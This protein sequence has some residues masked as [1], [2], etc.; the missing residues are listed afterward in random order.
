MLQ[1]KATQLPEKMQ[2][3]IMP[4]EDGCWLWT[5]SRQSDGYG[6]YYDR[7]TYTLAHRAVWLAAGRF[8]LEGLVSDHLCRQRL[9]VNP[10]HLEF[11]T[12]RENTLRGNTLAARFARRTHCNKGHE[13]T[14]ENTYWR[15]DKKR[16][17]RRCLACEKQRT[18]R[19]A[20][21]RAGA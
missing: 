19:R 1:M 21:M 8:I 12:S 11:V 18:V 4:V 2:D 15:S 20:A 13:Y 14:E 3:R 10:D 6:Y 17:A 5:G 9:C 16:R 7:G